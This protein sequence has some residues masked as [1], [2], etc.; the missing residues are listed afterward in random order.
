MLTLDLVRL[1]REKKLE[2]EDQVPGDSEIWAGSELAFDGPVRVE[3]TAS[4]TPE[5]GVVFRGSWEANLRYDCGRCTEPL[6]HTARRELTLV[7][8]PSEGWEAEDPEVRTINYNDRTLDLTETIREEVLLEVPR[9]LVPPTDN[10]GRCAKCSI[11]IDEFGLETKA[12][13]D[14]PRWAKLKAHRK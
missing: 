5:G 6:V 9:Y 13:T 7:Y 10:D 1:Q 8:M 3:G 12:E 14:D 4:R 2:V 11:P